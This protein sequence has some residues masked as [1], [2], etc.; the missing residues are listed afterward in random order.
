MQSITV[1][2]QAACDQGSDTYI[3][4]STGY[5]VMTSKALLKQGRCCGNSCR[6]CPYGHINVP[7]LVSRPV[8]PEN[9]IATQQNPGDLTK[10]NKPTIEP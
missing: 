10:V 1:L 2:H 5:Q 3:D 4:P 9:L 8:D 6:H 7:K